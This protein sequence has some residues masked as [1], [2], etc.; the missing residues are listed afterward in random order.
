MKEKKKHV[1]SNTTL[2]NSKVTHLQYLLVCA[3]KQF[4]ASDV[5]AVKTG[6]MITGS[7]GQSLR[8]LTTSEIPGLETSLVPW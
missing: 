3:S 4:I 1:L 8:L 2:S 6:V 5:M 7:K